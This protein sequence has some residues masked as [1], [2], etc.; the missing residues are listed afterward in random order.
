M[1]DPIDRTGK[2]VSGSLD[3]AS[4]VVLARSLEAR[5][6]IVVHVADAAPGNARQARGGFRGGKRLG[7]LDATRALAALLPAGLALARALAAAATVKPGLVAERLGSDRQCVDGVRLIRAGVTSCRRSFCSVG[8]R[9]P[10]S[11]LRWVAC[12]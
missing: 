11:G 10:A 1:H 12:L 2:R 3:A 7:V 9:Y 5:G 8:L 6:L 4:A